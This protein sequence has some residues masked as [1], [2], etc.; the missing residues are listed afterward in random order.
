M[1]APSPSPDD[2]TQSSASTQ[3]AGR[4]LPWLLAFV[5]LCIG[6]ILGVRLFFADLSEELQRRSENERARLFIGEEIVRGIQAMERDIYQMAVTQNRAG[7]QRIQRAI[8]TRMEKIRGDL[9]VLQEGGVATRSLSLNLAEQQEKALEVRFQPTEE[10]RKRI[11]EEIEVG[12]NLHLLDQLTEELGN[13]LEKRWQTLERENYRD[14]YRTEEEIALYIKRIPPYFERLQENANRLFIEGEQ[15]LQSLESE[16]SGKQKRL[17]QAETG[18]ILLVIFLAAL[19]GVQFIRQLNQALQASRAYGREAALQSERIA[20]ILDTLSDGVYAT[21]GEGRITFINRAGEHLLGWDGGTLLGESAHALT[22]HSHCDGSPYPSGEC[23]LQTVARQGEA[24]EGEECFFRKNGEAFPASYRAAPLTFEGQRIGALISFQDIGARKA[25]EMRIRLLEKAIQESD[26]GIMI[27]AADADFDGPSIQYVNSGFTQITGYSAGDAQG[28]RTALLRGPDTDPQT[29]HA[30]VDRLRRGERFTAEIDYRRKDGSLLAAEIDYSPV[31]DGAGRISHFIAHL[32]DIGTRRAAERALREAHDQALA[33]VQM[34]S[35]FLANMSHEIRTPM[36]GIIGMTDLLLD[37]ELDA[38]Q[39]DFAG[40]VRDSANSLLTIINDILDFS[41]IEAGKLDIESIDFS[42]QQV[43]EGVIDL[44]APR[45]ADKHLSLMSYIDPGLNDNLR[46]DPTRLRQVLLN[47][48]GN[49]VKFTTQGG[50][51]IAVM[52]RAEIAEEHRLRFEVRDTGIGI[53]DEGQR[54]LFQSFS[55]ADG[56]TTRKF[57][58]TGLGLAISK[59]LVSLM[60][61][62]IGV[63]SQEGQ[64]S[65]FWFELPLPPG[66][67]RQRP[68]R[69]T[70]EQ[71]ANERIL[72]VDDRD[73]DRTV[74]RRYLNSWGIDHACVAHARAALATIDEAIAAKRPF[75][76]ALIDYRMPEIDGLQ[77]ADAIRS[78]PAGRSM[79]LV[80]M[81]A[82]DQ[83]EL[84]APALAAGFSACLSKPLHQSELFNTLFGSETPAE[85]SS[86]NNEESAVSACNLREAVT[87]GR[88]V[89]LA[90]DNPTNQKVAELQLRKIG[91]RTHIVGNGLLAAQTFNTLPFA[92]LLMDCQMPVMDGFEATALIRRIEQEEGLPRMPIIA[93]TANAMQGDREHCLAVGMDDYVSKPIN[94][95]HLA[96]ALQRW[97]CPHDQGEAEKPASPASGDE[98]TETAS[99]LTALRELCDD[100]DTILHDLLA[101]F[102]ET[103]PALLDQLETALSR[104]SAPML[105]A[106]AH[107]IKG[108]CSNLCFNRLAASAKV[109]EATATRQPEPDWNLAS[110]ELA[111]LQQHYLGIQRDLQEQSLLA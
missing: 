74:L 77:L 109:L 11:M 66:E 32:S 17:N 62:N 99:A 65:T 71:S 100:D 19:T 4:S 104:R 9:K 80:L 63:S 8:G 58:G 6:L 25:A 52:A 60:G 53:S 61:G 5:L 91:Y 26:Q 89:L 56:S 13:L 45:A 69:T 73:T 51:E 47:L 86:G 98:G 35:E 107:E 30:L 50:V 92:A 108:S 21:D 2:R 38:E 59:Q 72:V 88:L 83:R 82:Y 106:A 48:I 85:A 39:R 42:L 70:P 55:Q 54:R 37:T 29:V 7:Y 12:S 67:S 27:T 49:A 40:L 76:A 44:L 87:Q 22:H 43:V 79:R 15:R 18:L 96:A 90:E 16:I 23:P 64:G 101:V 36:N 34:K 10:D 93:M 33:N 78:G 24:H 75:S 84:S 14:F 102:V 110:R 46:G 105:E 1:T 20:T 3:S 41:K 68:L 111:Q 28:R 81:T 94:T 103:M 31:H 57:G 95:E 97:S